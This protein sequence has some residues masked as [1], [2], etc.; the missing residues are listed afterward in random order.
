MDL[1]SYLLQMFRNKNIKIVLRSSHTGK[2]IETIKF[3]KDESNQIREIAQQ[4]GYTEQQ[5]F[6]K[7]F[8]DLLA[9]LRNK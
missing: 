8:S 4:I 3:S 1:A 2:K 6:D 7:I 9:E 5:L